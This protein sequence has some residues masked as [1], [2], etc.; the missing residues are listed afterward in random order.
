[1]LVLLRAF[2]FGLANKHDL[3][4]QNIFVLRKMDEVLAAFQP[5]THA[6]LPAGQIRKPLFPFIP[7]DRVLIDPLH[8][9]LRIGGK[10]IDLAFEEALEID[11]AFCT[12]C[13]KGGQK[14]KSCL[15]D[16]ECQCECHQKK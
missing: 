5:C 3:A 8:A 4:A 14:K 15:G 12:N 7:F 13:Y 2:V 1:M 9:F 6:S 11:F 16:Q 10:L